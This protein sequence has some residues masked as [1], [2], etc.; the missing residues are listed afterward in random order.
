MT[1]IAKRRGQSR[2]LSEVNQAV[3]LSSDEAARRLALHGPN[4]LRASKGTPLWRR[5]LAQFQDPLTYLLLGAVIVAIAVWAIEGQES[6][7]ID[8]VVLAAV[9]L[10]NAA[11]GFAQES[12]AAN[13]VAALAR[14]TAV[15]SSVL[16]DGERRR[17]PSAELVPGDVLLLEEGDAVGADARLLVTAALRVQEASLTGESEAVL[18]D[19]D[20]IAAA[21]ADRRTVEH[22]FQ[23][24][25]GGAKKTAAAS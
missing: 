25:G 22:D 12:K 4:E 7:P 1:L 15:T 13:A 2:K 9:I 5:I 21:D 17:L 20:L 14:M 23:G 24:D 16:R 18:K 3:G 8:A 6:W 10:L 11:L 19:A